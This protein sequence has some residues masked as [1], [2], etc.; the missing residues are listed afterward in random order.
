VQDSRPWLSQQIVIFIESEEESGSAY[1]N[2]YLDVLSDEK[3]LHPS[4]VAILDSGG[5]DHNHRV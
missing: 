2:Y 5:N 1:L 4:F 3:N